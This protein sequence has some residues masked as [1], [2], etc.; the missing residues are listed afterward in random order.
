MNIKYK[1]S[2]PKKK[3]KE[4]L[5]ANLD[6]KQTIFKKQNS[7]TEK[8]TKASYLVSYLIAKTMKP[9]RKENLSRNV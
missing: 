1:T 4:K 7:K 6:I 8:N 5:K 9:F 2:E 3:K